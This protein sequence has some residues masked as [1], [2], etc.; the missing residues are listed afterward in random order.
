MYPWIWQTLP[1]SLCTKHDNS[2]DIKLIISL[3]VQ[4]F[5]YNKT[6]ISINLLKIW[7]EFCKWEV[8]RVATWKHFIPMD[9]LNVR[10]FL[11]PR[12]IKIFVIRVGWDTQMEKL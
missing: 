5:G 8:S 3:S 4:S 9:C 7:F 10:Y 6:A 11:T 2:E 1:A 12:S